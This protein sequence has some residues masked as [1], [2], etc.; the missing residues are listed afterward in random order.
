MSHADGASSSTTNV[1]NIP[2][3]GDVQQGDGQQLPVV[4]VETDLNA[5]KGEETTD[6]FEVQEVQSQLSQDIPPLP[7]PDPASM[8][9]LLSN[10][11]DTNN[12]NDHIMDHMDH[13][14][15]HQVQQDP[16]VHTAAVNAGDDPHTSMVVMQDVPIM[17]ANSTTYSHL[18]IENDNH[19]HE[20][21]SSMPAVATMTGMVPFLTT[22]DGIPYHPSVSPVAAAPSAAT[23]GA[24]PPAAVAAHQ[25]GLHGLQLQ[26]AMEQV[27]QVPTTTTTTTTTTTA[28]SSTNPN[29]TS[30]NLAP[31]SHIILVQN[32]NEKQ[33]S[34]LQHDNTTPRRQQREAKWDIMYSYLVQYK[35]IHGD[36]LV[37]NRYKPLPQL[38]NWV[39]TQRR[40]YNAISTG[41][42]SPLSMEK[43]EL[44]N[45][46]GFV[47]KT[48]DPRHVSDE[49]LVVVTGSSTSSNQLAMMFLVLVVSLT[50]LQI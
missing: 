48:K 46:I 17:D 23:G 30:S 50:F 1:P 19:H 32:S 49:F 10:A 18:S 29:S 37:P 27:V 8:P 16:T 28:L 24:L 34:K 43:V 36:C 47:W 6:S 35:D 45:K 42:I 33:K 20:T 12:V 14:D 7:N 39:S 2:N 41:A 5:S 15:H 31:Q 25:D 21:P 40:H 44:L 4:L 13:M 38:G 9:V 26:V 22:P 11:N 3:S